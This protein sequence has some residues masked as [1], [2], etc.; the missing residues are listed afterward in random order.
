MTN[1][2][3]IFPLG[4]V[5]YPG[6]KLHL[7]IFEPR[8]KQLIL[9]CKESGKPFGIP[10]VLSN[11][12]QEMG[13]LVE[14]KEI[15]ETYTNGEMDIKTEGVQVFRVLEVIKTIPD[16]LYSGAIVNYPENDIVQANSELMQKVVRGIKELHRL[17]EISKDFKKADL[18][19]SSYDI[20]HHMGLSVEEEYEVLVL[21]K[22]LHRGEYLKRHLQK[23]LPLLLEMEQLKKKV[24]RN[25]HFNN[26][27]T[28][29][30]DV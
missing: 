2:I 14:L 7:H 3:P 9:E 17:L 19:L 10:T 25:G 1:F 24:K 20:A 23:A 8:Y 11:K 13:T 15:V 29:D 26:L 28:F 21:L 6:E 5:V 16:K 22:E 30:L 18:D 27:S 12:M 4:I